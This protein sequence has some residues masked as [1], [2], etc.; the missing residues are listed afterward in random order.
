MVTTMIKGISSARARLERMYRSIGR[1]FN[2]VDACDR[3]ANLVR[4]NG[5][6][7]HPVQRWFHLKEA[8]SIDLLEN[9]MADWHIRP[10]SLRRVLDPFCGIGTTLLACERLARRNNLSKLDV[11][12]IERNPF[13]HFA[14]QTKLSWHTYDEMRFRSLAEELLKSEDNA[15]AVGVPPLSTLWRRDVYD[16]RVLKRLVRL[17]E[18]ITSLNHGWPEKAPLLLGFA[19]ILESVSGVRKDG[20]ALR[21]VPGKKRARMSMAI[22]GAWAAVGSDLGEAAEIFKRVRVRVSLGDGRTLITAGRRISSRGQFDLIVYSPPYLNNIDY[23]EVYKIELWLCE[24]VQ[25]SEEFRTLRHSTFRS[26]P[27]VRF[28]SPI[29]FLKDARMSSIGV[30]LGTLIEALP[31]DHNRAWRA[32]LFSSYFDDMYVSLV[33]QYEVLRPGGWV[34]CVVGNSM[35]GPAKQPEQR[36]PV[37]S[38]LMI[39]MIARKL[40][41]EVKAVQI[42]RQLHRRIPSN[43]Y[44]RESI[45]ALRKPS[46]R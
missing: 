27:S 43:G 29:T 19:S 26:H 28:R 45:L 5:N 14:A 46:K 23:S 33:N 37:A 15:G 17:R 18:R 32:D 31:N 38:D 8:F 42:A 3:Y 39:A 12:G 24:F 9:L 40:G 20:R 36:V 1:E 25:T 30:M 34:F 21:I 6:G 41:F 22:R 11:V 10:E 16:R 2:I 13:L 4:A 44:M 7:S 35:H